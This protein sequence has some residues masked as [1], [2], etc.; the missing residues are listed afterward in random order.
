[1]AESDDGGEFGFLLAVHL[2]VDEVHG[3]RRE[4]AAVRSRG[5][6]AGQD[7]GGPV[8]ATVDGNSA[9]RPKQQRLKE[10]GGEQGMGKGLGKHQTP[11]GLTC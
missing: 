2:L 7:F 9:R 1:M 4:S 8:G 11:T 6:S 3:S 5:K 10:P